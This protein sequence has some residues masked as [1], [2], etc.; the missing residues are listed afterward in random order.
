MSSH[1]LLDTQQD[2]PKIYL[3]YAKSGRHFSKL[4]GMKYYSTLD[5]WAWYHHIP[6]D[7]LSIPKTAFT[8]PFGKYE[9]IKV[10]FGLAQAPVY[11]Q[12]LITGVLKDFPFTMAYLDDIIVLS[13]T[14]EEHLDHIR[15]V[16]KKL[17]NVQLLMKLSKCH[18]FAKEIQYLG[19]ILITREHQT[20]TIKDLGHQQHA[21]TENSQT[22][23]CLP[24]TCWILEEILS[25]TSLR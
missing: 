6:L 3:A 9:Y 14:T 10:P 17:Q 13:R 12:E 19:H 8:S 7:E 25:G 18:F 22:N 21:S 4:N 16:F 11:F 20:T 1:P 23:R 15:Q 5:L 24:R 2:H